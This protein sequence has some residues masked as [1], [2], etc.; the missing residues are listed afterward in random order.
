[1]LGNRI[2]YNRGVGINKM[3][4]VMPII[5]AG[6]LNM[7][8]TKT[9]FY[10]KHKRPIDNRRSINNKRIL[11]DN[12]T[13]IGFGSMVIISGFTHVIWGYI[14]RLLNLESKSDY[15]VKHDNRIT[16]NLIV[17]LSNGFIYMVSELP[18]SFI[19]RRL[20]IDSGKRAN[21]IK[22]VLFYIIDQI[23]SI[24]GIAYLIKKLS[25]I[26]VRETLE[27]IGIGGFVH[28]IINLILFKI[29]VRENI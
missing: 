9:K 19:K 25:K 15:Y 14:L 8:F 10:N 22:G 4:T 28:A 1:M 26:N 27:Y 17:G 3:I 24:V 18:N 20:D 29:K 21:G 6:I 11:G 2:F 5:F 23:D 13:W 12:K 7:L 16:Y